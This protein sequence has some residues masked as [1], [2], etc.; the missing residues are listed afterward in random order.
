VSSFKL[1]DIVRIGTPTDGCWWAEGR[2]AIVLD[3]ADLDGKLWV[4]V[5]MSGCDWPVRGTVEAGRCEK[6]G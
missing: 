2:S 3:G 6:R 4:G 1:G 5:H